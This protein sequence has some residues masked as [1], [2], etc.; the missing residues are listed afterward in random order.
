M[1]SQKAKP[2]SFWISLDQKAANI[3]GSQ[4]RFNS[5]LLISNP[6]VSNTIAYSKG[7]P[8]MPFGDPRK[9]FNLMFGKHDVNK[10]R[11]SLNF[12]KSIMDTVREHATALQKEVSASD[13][14]KLDEY[15]TTVQ[16]TEKKIIRDLSWLDKP[17]PKV[18]LS[19]DGKP[20]YSNNALQQQ[21]Y[22]EYRDIIFDLMHLAF[23]FDMTRVIS[24]QMYSPHHGPTH[25]GNRESAIKFLLENDTRM[26]KS[27]ARF[28]QKLNDT[29]T[30]NGTL[31]D[32]TTTILTSV[33]GD[34]NSHSGK[35]VPVILVGGKYQTG[36]HVNR[37]GANTCD[38]YISLLNQMGVNSKSFAS[39]T[40]AMDILS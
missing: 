3:V 36:K 4:T 13:R 14:E 19:F 10:K 23:K 27:F 34:A 40:K 11:A 2:G 15:F 17:I 31:M 30:A 18:E 33:L 25:H 28:Q 38:L 6:K 37:P 26:M 5:L 39:G 24:F 21:Q 16:E 1:R 12:D 22:L 20:D 8:L 35:N 7:M 32:E 29:K 9:V